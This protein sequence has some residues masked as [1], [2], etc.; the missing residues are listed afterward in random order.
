MSRF[1]K[2]INICNGTYAF[3]VAVRPEASAPIYIGMGSEP[4]SADSRWAWNSRED[5]E[6]MI[7]LLLEVLAVEVDDE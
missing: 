2:A 5:I 4:M 7:D 3:R 6:K 1:E